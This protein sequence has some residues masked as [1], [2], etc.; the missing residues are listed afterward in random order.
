[1]YTR[2]ARRHARPPRPWPAATF[3]LAGVCTLLTTA[4]TRASAQAAPQRV[5]PGD[6]RRAGV[7]VR[8]TTPFA[9]SSSGDVNLRIAIRGEVRL[10]SE[11]DRPMADAR[12]DLFTLMRSRLAARVSA[13]PTVHLLM[14]VQDSRVLGDNG[15]TARQTFDLHQ[16]YVELTGAVRDADLQLRAGRQEIALANER[17]VGAVAW[18]NPGRTFD[19]VRLGAVRNREGTTSTPT[20]QTWTADAFVA[21]LEERGRHFTAR[22]TDT[23]YDHTFGGLFL[24]NGTGG[25]VLAQLTALA[26][27]GADFRAYR[28]AT[29]GTIDVRVVAPRAFGLRIE[30]EG[31]VQRGTQD[32]LTGV[33]TVA[34]SIA[35]WLLGVRVGMPPSVSRRVSIGVGADLLSGDNTPGDGTYA[36]FN[37]LYGTNHALYGTIDLFVDPARATK[38]RGLHDLFVTTDLMV[39]P[40]MRV[41]TDLHHMRAATGT[42]RHLGWELDVMAPLRLTDDVTLDLGYSAF[43]AGP[44]AATLGLGATDALQHWAFLQMRTQFHR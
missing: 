13:T 42:N 6:A 19:G 9:P 23:T 4:S 22:A 26:D 18:S 35:A 43:R 44:G 33:D 28:N 32:L 37:T 41:R 36:A 25:A 10:R 20:G 38:D 17:L 21:T 1:M 29:R 7:S 31:A 27:V 12:P 11:W 2:S 5:P 34:Q 14:E 40:T 16:G 15:A 8:D 39:S 3:L 24:T 30:A